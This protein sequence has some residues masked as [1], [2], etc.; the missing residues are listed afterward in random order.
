MKNCY[1]EHEDNLSSM[2]WFGQFSKSTSLT[3]ML[4]N[5]FKPIQH[6]YDLVCTV[7]NILKSSILLEVF[8]PLIYVFKTLL[9]S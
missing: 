7:V 9:C 8:F 2:K 6:F 1:A 3:K 5:N 4:K